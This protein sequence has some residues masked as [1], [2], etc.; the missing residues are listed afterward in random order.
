MW[1]KM[2]R[3]FGRL[4]V[5]FS[6]MRLL[7]HVIIMLTT[8]NSWIIKA[9]LARWAEVYHLEKPRKLI[10]FIVLFLTFMTLTPEFRNLFYLRSGL[11]ARAFS[12]LCPPIGTLQIV[13]TEIGPGLFI[14]H[15]LSTMI[16]ADSIGTNC[17]INQHVVIGFSNE[18]DRPTI[19]DNVRISA[20]AKIIGK[21]KIGNNA[22]IGPNTVVID[23]VPPNVTVLGVPGRVVWKKNSK[24]DQV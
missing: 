11:K 3:K 5:I 10:S 16:S 7:P 19:G 1:L 20:G 9:D 15:G 14:Q 24:P 4:R 17:W 22:T 21:F 13:P 12:W 23:D 8:K 18:T 6:S 2:N